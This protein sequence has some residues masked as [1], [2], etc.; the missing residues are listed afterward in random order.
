MAIPKVQPKT[1]FD[2]LQKIHGD[3]VSGNNNASIFGQSY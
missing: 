2:A 1:P 3:V